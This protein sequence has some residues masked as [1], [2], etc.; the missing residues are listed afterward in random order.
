MTRRKLVID[1]DYSAT[2]IWLITPPEEA[3]APAP[4]GEWRP[5]AGPRDPRR[6]WRGLLSDHLLDALQLWNDQGDLVMGRRAH[7]HTDED[8][9]AFWARARELAEEAQRQLGPD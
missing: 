7:Q 1:W 6:A 5:F 8:R 9:A 4:G 3:I 2:G